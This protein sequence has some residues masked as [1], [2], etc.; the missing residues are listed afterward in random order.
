MKQITDI[1]VINFRNSLLD[2]FAAQRR[3]LPWRDDR[4]WYKVW[5]SEIMLQQT[6]VKQAIP[7]FER[8]LATF[9]DIEQLADSPLPKVLKAWEGLGYYSR[10][11][12]LH[13]A[14]Q[15]IANDFGGM[16]PDTKTKLLTL[17]GIGPYTA[18]AI[19]S[20]VFNQ[21][22]SVV[23]GNVKRVV[24]RLFSMAGDIRSTKTVQRIQAICDRLLDTAQPGNFNEAM[25]ELGA[26]ICLPRTPNC[27]PCPLQSCCS[28]FQTSSV[29][30]FPARFRRKAAPHRFQHVA[31]CWSG[32][33]LLLARRSDD[34]LL[35]GMWELPYVSNQG[36]DDQPESKKLNEIDHVYSHF[37]I[38][39]IPVLVDT[40]SPL[41][42]KNY[43]ET[44]YVTLEEIGTLPVHKA[45]H[46]LIEANETI[47]ENP[48]RIK[49][50]TPK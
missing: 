25:M 32:N 19:L 12:N 4:H 26:T 15:Q 37:R 5:I 49:N 2:W 20:L 11:R 17:S 18:H 29:D 35:G 33:K 7:Y 22:Y 41:D 47:F 9:P 42:L 44:K 27:E 14:A 45:I 23:D 10:A 30:Q 24:S 40:V 8:F 39:L 13:K 3:Q 16:M 1:F 43:H 6:Q 36:N 48:G 28:A 34:G 46:K 31:I 38:T 21:P 50:H